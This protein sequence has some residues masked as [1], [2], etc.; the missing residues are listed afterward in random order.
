MHP[1][2]RKSI[3]STNVHKWSGRHAQPARSASADG[4]RAT[5]PSADRETCRSTA[6]DRPAASTPRPSSSH[7]RAQS[8]ERVQ[9]FRSGLHPN[10]RKLK[11]IQFPI[12]SKRT[13]K[14]ETVLFPHALIKKVN[15][16]FP[17]LNL[18]YCN[19]F[20]TCRLLIQRYVHVSKAS[21]IK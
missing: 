19:K 18:S 12:E 17:C 6:P 8:L 14:I 4:H 5:I 11:P 10:S 3:V 7:L 20:P 16:E 1:T 15:F 13:A 21:E 9:A 2:L